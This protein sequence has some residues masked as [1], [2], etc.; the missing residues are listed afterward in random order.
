MQR[1]LTLRQAVRLILEVADH[2]LRL[3]IAATTLLV[4]GGGVL[5]AAT[6]L[7]LKHLIDA[8]AASSPTAA[9]AAAAN[10][11]KQGAIYIGALCG[12]RVVADIRPLL[13]GTM[14]QELAAALRRRFFGHILRLPLGTLLKR[15]TG[16]TLHSLDLACAGIQLLIGHLTSSIIA[17]VVEL[18]VMT[19]VLAEL[20]QPA[21]VALFGA[22]A[23]LYVTVLGSSTIR[24]NRYA[25]AVT[26]E[27]LSVHGQLAE[28]LGSVETLRCFNAEAQ[29]RQ[30][31]EV[32]SSALVSRWRG[33]YRMA[34]STA[35][36]ASGV[37]ALSMTACLAISAHGVAKGELSV[38][39]L[40]L[41][42]VYLLQMLRPLEMMGSAVRDLSRANSLVRPLLAILRE[43]PEAVPPL[44]TPTPEA[45]SAGRR[46]PSLR[47]EHVT[48]G[49]DPIHPVIHALDLE[50]AA[51]STTA[52]VGPSGS[53]KSSLIR[54]LLRLYSP[55]QGRILLNEQPIEE[56][57]LADLRARFGLV[58]QDTTLLHASI[59]TN[60]ALGIPGA[61]RDAIIGASS[62]A[63]LHEAIESMPAGYDTLI[64]ERGSKLSG[65]ERQRLA[66]ARALL[67]R[68]QIFLL[69][70]PT[71]NLDS[72]TEAQILMTLRE[73]TRGCTTLVVA[74]RLATVTSADEIIVLDGGRIQER[75]RHADLVARNGLYTRLW[76]Q[77]TEGAS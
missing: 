13:T 18:A 29:A 53:G 15:R 54:L 9:T 7:A 23:L 72:N 26:T 19:W 68:P 67:R 25:D 52:I 2:R 37:F 61:T 58:P 1:L 39:G 5:S 41:S 22:T 20:Q 33:Y 45:V 55:Q 62:G 36:V 66:I 31:L 12:G 27:S 43:P 6:P 77:Q 8:V 60:I 56:M 47:L 38:G 28:G 11:L 16:E 73:A 57:P 14:D 35:I 21:L 34:A 44:S 59:A 74:H 4:V 46:A 50:I 30:A 71:S 32:A 24:L 49:Y 64:G 76:R 42:S 10:V 17:V 51:G 3:H 48:F 65:G 70:E 63:R 40:V 75:G 69:D